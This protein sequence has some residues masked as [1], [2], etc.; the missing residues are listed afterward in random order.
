MGGVGVVCGESLERSGIGRIGS[1]IGWGSAGGDVPQAAACWGVGGS[2]SDGWMQGGF[3]V[4]VVLGC[5]AAVWSLLFRQEGGGEA[6][7]VGVGCSDA[8][9][10]FSSQPRS[11]GGWN[12]RASAPTSA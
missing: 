1:E 11:I 4:I 7:R 5:S 8:E 9:V 10:Q 12:G 3:P 6:R 2:G